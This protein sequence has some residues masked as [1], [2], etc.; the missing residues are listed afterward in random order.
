MSGGARVHIF[1]GAPVGPLEMTVSQD[2]TSLMSTTTPWKE[3]RLLRDEHSGRL[4]DGGLWH[5]VAESRWG[6]EAVGPPGLR[7]HSLSRRVTS[8]AP[9]KDDFARSVSETQA[10]VPQQSHPTGPSHAAGSTEQTGRGEDGAEPVGDE[11]TPPKLLGGHRTAVGGPLE[12][13]AG[14]CGQSLQTGSFPSGLPCAGLLDLVRGTEQIHVGSDP[15]PTTR[16]PAESHAMQS[17]H[18]QFLSSDPGDLPEGEGAGGPGS[19][20]RVSAHTEFLSVMTASQVAFLAQRKE[21]GQASINEGTTSEEAGP[22]ASPG[23]VTAVGAHL[24]PPDGFAEGHGSD[25]TQVYSL[26]L[27]SPICPETRNCPIQAHPGHS[28]EGTA[29]CPEPL[30]SDAEW[31]PEGLHIKLC[32]AGVLCSQPGPSPRSAGK[33]N[34]APDDN[35]AHSG[36]PSKVLQV[37]KKMR[38]VSKPRASAGAR[39]PGAASALEGLRETSLIR[40][41]GSAGRKYNCL[42]MVLSPCHVKEIHIRSGPNAGTK[43]PL[44]TIT[45]IDQSDRKRRVCLWRAAAFWALTVFLG[46]I[47]LLTDVTV[48]EDQW[49]GETTLQSTLTSQLLNLGNPSSI[50]PGGCSHIVSDAVLQDLLAYVSSKHSYLRDLPPRRPPRAGSVEFAE[51][52]RLQ[53]D[54]LVHARLRV[55]EV[56]VLTEAS[57]TYRGQT[58]RKVLVTVE[59]AQ[60]QRYVLALWG[61]GAAWCPQLQRRKDYIWEFKYLFV[62]RNCI[63]ESLELHTTPWSSCECLFDDDTRAVSFKEHFQK[64]VSSPVKISDLATH[65]KDKCSGVVL[66]EARVLELAF[67]ITAAQKLV[68][69]ARSSLKTVFSS[70]PSLVYTG[71]AKCGLEL[72]LDE[73]KIYTQ[74]LRCLPFTA[75]KT[76][77]RPAV[78]TVHDGRHDVGISVGPEL[79]EKLLLHI[80]ADRLRSAIVPSSEVTYGLVAADLLHSLLA[81][82]GEPCVLKIQSLFVLDENSCPLRQDF[83]LLDLRLTASSAELRPS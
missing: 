59:Q 83:S 48:R 56:T 42:V 80:P 2:T 19:G 81:V 39:S 10:T 69:N 23:E 53:P 5:G 40:D 47:V 62:Q 50:R 20:L 6:P 32:S 35:R 45:V 17:Q 25:Q 75:T 43:V 33:R 22:E 46:D 14:T 29:A 63:L 28:P 79:V 61:P 1:W 68:L 27:F 41:C 18:P 16:V 26:E 15:V 66:I 34:R 82:S 38:L 11:G 67:P 3:A 24:T 76:H 54:V 74:C 52:E 31:P 58:Q 60:G 55:V 64:S 73:N 78:M 71:C 70:L 49:V 37:A 51:L 21:K 9:V 30:G 12:A 44:A 65:L 57:Y 13:R 4:R 8:P 36:A 77:Y 72:E 7:E